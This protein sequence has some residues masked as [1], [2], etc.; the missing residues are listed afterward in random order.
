[1]AAPP[2]DAGALHVNATSAF[3]LVPDTLVGVP[4]VVNER[5][6]RT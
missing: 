3:P 6:G 1:M 4:G 5:I 2:V